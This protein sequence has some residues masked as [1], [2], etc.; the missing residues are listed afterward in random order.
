VEIVLPKKKNEVSEIKINTNRIVI[1]GANGAGKTRF[2]TNLENRYNSITHR[3]S[4]QKSLSMP[5]T[6]SPKS[7]EIA[8]SELFYG[9][10]YENNNDLS[11]RQKFNNRWGNKP[12]TFLLND[13]EK[14]MVL[15]HTEEYEESIKFKEA[16]KSS[17]NVTTPITKLDTIQE[18]FE[19]VISHRKLVKKAGTIEVYPLLDEEKQYNASEMSDGERIVFY[20]IGEV[21]CAK[22]NSLIIIDEPE[23]HLNKAIVKKLW[24]K[25]EQSRPDCTFVYL[26]HDI[27]FAVSRQDVTK[28]W[29]KS[30][31]G[32]NVWDYQVLEEKDTL[33]ETLYLEVLGSRK[34]ILFVE[35][36]NKSSIDFQFYEQIFTEYTIKPLNSCD[37]VFEATSAFNDLKD[38]HHIDSFGLIDRD[39]RTEEQISHIQ[40]K[41]IWVSKVVEVESFLL[42][43]EIVKAVAKKMGKNENEVFN[44]VKNNIILEFKKHIDEEATKYT[45]HKIKNDFEKKL[46]PKVK[47]IGELE[48]KLNEYN[49]QL[50]PQEI[51]EKIKEKFEK[52]VS[53]KDYIGVLENYNNKGLISISKV[54]SLCDLNTKN[55]AYLNQVISILKDNTDNS[56]VIKEVVNN[57]IFKS[58]E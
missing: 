48:S 53:N 20:L 14:L 25:I 9:F 27:D 10:Y 23:N 21:V 47:N 28:I 56:R 57:M 39:R 15:L 51:Y 1:I 29:M 45:L 42:L 22:D 16:S 52:I 6:V 36:N 13:Y 43:E 7:K 8:E 17:N 37:K 44:D 11:L 24:D 19:S 3:V 12:N 50:N 33:P 58:K 40:N 54:A 49:N 38:F 46:N 5:K 31:E 35:G 4:A 32:D 30:Y 34:P 55:N 26:T 18:I 2:S 41:N